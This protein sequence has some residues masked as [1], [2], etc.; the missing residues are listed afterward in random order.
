M[1]ITNTSDIYLYITILGRK[2]IRIMCQN[3]F[4]PVYKGLEYIDL[5]ERN[6]KQMYDQLKR[7]YN[8]QREKKCQMS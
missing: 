3:A 8:N 2:K 5:T 4:Y 1:K 6:R 7:R